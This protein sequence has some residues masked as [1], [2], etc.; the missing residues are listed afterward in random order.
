M[1][2]V[3][4]GFSC[5]CL[6]HISSTTLALKKQCPRFHCE[7]D[8]SVLSSILPPIPVKAD[9]RIAQ[10]KTASDPEKMLRIAKALSQAKITRSLQILDWLAEACEHRNLNRRTSSFVCAYDGARHLPPGCWHLEV[11]EIDDNRADSRDT[12]LLT[13]IAVGHNSPSVVLSPSGRV[14]ER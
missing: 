4:L 5:S 10:I 12:R 9:V 13:I 6:R 1:R 2:Q 11:M 14:S 7:F 8:C 3:G